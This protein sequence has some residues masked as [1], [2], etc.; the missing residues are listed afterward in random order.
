MQVWAKL[1]FAGREG[2]HLAGEKYKTEFLKYSGFLNWSLGTR[3]N[4]S[5]GI[6]A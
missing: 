1:C 2:R 6:Y 4:I 3:G 5:L